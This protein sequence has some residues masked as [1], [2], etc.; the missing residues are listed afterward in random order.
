MFA[1]NTSLFLTLVIGA[2]ITEFRRQA[3]LTGEGILLQ[4][5][6]K[7]LNT[8]QTKLVAILIVIRVV[9]CPNNRLCSPAGL[10]T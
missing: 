6:K 9:K 3:S 5:P 2:I 10:R 8:A 4:E 7:L 1:T